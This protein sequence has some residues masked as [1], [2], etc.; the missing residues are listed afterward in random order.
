MKK[1]YIAFAAIVLVTIAG[2]AFYFLSKPL[3]EDPMTPRS[4]RGNLEAV[5]E[6]EIALQ[7][8]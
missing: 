7:N 5:V 3:Y 6:A 2:I 4:V 8:V 1:Q